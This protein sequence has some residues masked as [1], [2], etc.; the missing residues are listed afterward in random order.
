VNFCVLKSV[1]TKNF[2][3]FK[4]WIITKNVIREEDFEQLR[5]ID[6]ILSERA[7]RFYAPGTSAVQKEQC[8]LLSVDSKSQSFRAMPN[9]SSE[10]DYFSFEES[11]NELSELVGT[12]GISFTFV[13]FIF[14]FHIH[15]LYLFIIK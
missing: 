13:N 15:F 12:A 1:E 11:L 14:I 10:D 7:A 5:N 8:I 3:K 4:Q 9:T 2:N 6:L